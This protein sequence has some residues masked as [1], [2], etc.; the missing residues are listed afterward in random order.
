M[1]EVKIPNLNK[2]KKAFGS[3][4]SLFITEFQRAISLAGRKIEA[5]SKKVTPVDR[6]RLRASIRADIGRLQA[7]VAPHTEYAVFVHE[8]TSRMKGR[9]FMKQ[10]TDKANVIKLFEEAEKRI[11]IKIANK[12]R[13]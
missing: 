8:G 1:I 2:L 13:I 7:I 5:E 11:L 10:G 3:H 6:G 12:S 4:R 9:P